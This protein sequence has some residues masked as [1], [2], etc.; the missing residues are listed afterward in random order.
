MAE[1]D[2]RTGCPLVSTSEVPFNPLGPFPPGPARVLCTPLLVTNWGG[3]W[4]SERQVRFQQQPRFSVQVA[5]NRKLPKRSLCILRPNTVL[6]PGATL[7]VC[8]CVLAAGPLGLGSKRQRFTSI[9]GNITQPA[10]PLVC[11]GG[12]G[13][14]GGKQRDEVPQTS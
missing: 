14:F 6:L 9:G 10:G 1:L 11:C 12:C 13:S 2:R 7:L 8:G 5:K 3:G 4:A